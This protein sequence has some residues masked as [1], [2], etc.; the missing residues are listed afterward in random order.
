MKLKILLSIY[1]LF[2]LSS[3]LYSQDSLKMIMPIGHT[4]K[5]NKIIELNNSDFLV[6]CSDDFTCKIWDKRTGKLIKN[7]KRNTR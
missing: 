3:V 5:I 1:Y 4:L 6:S 2:F 7:L